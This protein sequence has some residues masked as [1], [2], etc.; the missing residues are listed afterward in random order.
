[1]GGPRKRGVKILTAL[2]GEDYL[3]EHGITWLAYSDQGVYLRLPCNSKNT[4]HLDVKFSRLVGDGRQP[5]FN[6]FNVY[7]IQAS[8]NFA[9][10]QGEYRDVCGEQVLEL[11]SHVLGIEFNKGRVTPCQSV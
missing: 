9:E 1:M 7:F 4:T 10:T 2:G 3:N 8:A 6:K 5:Q 11:I